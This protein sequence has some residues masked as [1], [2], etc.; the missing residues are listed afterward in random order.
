MTV[1]SVTKVG[2]GSGLE[3]C[4]IL[5]GTGVEMLHASLSC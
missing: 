3:P 4:L 5:R 2:S 1:S